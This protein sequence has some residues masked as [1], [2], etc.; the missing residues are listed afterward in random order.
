MPSFPKPKIIYKENLSQEIQAIRQHKDKKPGRKIPRSTSDNLLLA[1]WNIANLGAQDRKETHLKIIAEMCSWYDIIA[2]QE[3]KENHEHLDKIVH[4]MGSQYSYICSDAGGNNERMAF[5]FNSKKI[6]LLNEVAE[7]AIPPSEYGTIKIN[8]SN[9]SFVGFDRNPYIVSFQV[10]KLKFTLM[11]VHLYFGDE[12]SRTSLDRRGLEAFCVARAAAIRSKSKY[13]FT[14]TVF[15]LGD[16][17]LPKSD[18]SNVIYKAL[19]AKGLQVPVHTSKIYSNLNNDRAYDQ[20]AFFPGYKSLIKTHG[21]FD[22]DNAIFAEIYETRLAT[23]FRSYVRYY[24]SD[25]RPMWME[26]DI[27]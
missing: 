15:A 9:A 26:L 6:K 23:E 11:N 22:F 13:A 21:I 7:L 25:H 12:T 8:D 20:I 1:T 3:V 17:N 27:K 2:I 24:I 19:I 16:F 10:K 14:N 5:I 4:F 18:L